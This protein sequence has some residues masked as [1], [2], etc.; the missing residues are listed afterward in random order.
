MVSEPRQLLGR[1]GHGI[2]P[3]WLSSR[4]GRAK[5]K[6][7][8]LGRKAKRRLIG[9]DPR[10]WGGTARKKRLLGSDPRTW[11]PPLRAKQRVRKTPLA[12]SRR[13]APPGMLPQR[14]ATRYSRE[15]MSRA[16]R[17]GKRKGAGLP[18]SLERYLY[19]TDGK[20]LA[21]KRRAKR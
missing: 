12:R 11:G 10:T 14:A 20:R 7:I 6:L 1:D 18:W 21:R 8:G 13:T 19:S 9:S 3:A 16:I 17:N 5:R 2:T 15:A 4:I